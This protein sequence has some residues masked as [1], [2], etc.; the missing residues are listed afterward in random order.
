MKSE[1]D[2]LNSITLIFLQLLQV[3]TQMPNVSTS[4][5]AYGQISG[6]LQRWLTWRQKST[7]RT[8]ACSY[9]SHLHSYRNPGGHQEEP[10]TLLGCPLAEAR[11][12]PTACETSMCLNSRPLTY[13]TR[14]QAIPYRSF[15]S[16]RQSSRD[17]HIHRHGFDLG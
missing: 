3:S 5:S 15:L 17:S 16:S 12:I 2:G 14:T 9:R 1:N 7:P 6:K 11:V 10:G 8:R 13:P 4:G